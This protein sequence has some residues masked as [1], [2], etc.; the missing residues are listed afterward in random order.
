MTLEL[1]REIKLP[2][3]SYQSELKD[4]EKAK[5]SKTKQNYI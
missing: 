4:R 1:N 2:Q 5:T 3:T